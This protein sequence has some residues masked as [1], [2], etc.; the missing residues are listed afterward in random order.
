MSAIGAA[1]RC[2]GGCGKERGLG[3]RRRRR[4]RRQQPCLSSCSSS[5]CCPDLASPAA[6][7]SPPAASPSL[8]AA[9]VDRAGPQSGRRA[10]GCT[11]PL[12]PAGCGLGTA[13]AKRLWRRPGAGCSAIVTAEQREP[14]R[15]GDLFVQHLGPRSRTSYPPP[16]RRSAA[17]S[18]ARE[19]DEDSYF[20]IWGICTAKWI[21]I[22]VQPYCPPVC[23]AG[24]R[25]GL[26]PCGKICPAPARWSL[27]RLTE[28]VFLSS[29]GEL[30][31]PWKCSRKASRPLG[32]EKW[33]PFWR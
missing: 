13:V 5:C 32:L 31:C 26:F 14:G 10:S 23:S 22:L 4:R 27:W 18:S 2:Y 16:F 9:A 8:G 11:H 12:G 19:G 33:L 17:R 20:E 30:F 6:C 29:A 28:A 7:V 21:W 24:K 3:R 25:D 15:G 1:R